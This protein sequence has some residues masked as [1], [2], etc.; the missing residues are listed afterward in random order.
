MTRPSPTPPF[1][2]LERRPSGA[3]GWLDARLLHDRWLEDLGADATAVLVLL[4]LAADRRGA[5]FYSRE[6]MARLLSLDLYRT[7]K[8]LD[9][10][11]EVKLVAHKPWR[12]GTRDGV[13]QLLPVPRLEIHRTGRMTSLADLID[14]AD[15]HD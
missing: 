2:S 6:R 14:G 15:P 5:S 10:L 7:D 11:I 1:P 3:F 4:A 8:A 12:E 9:R 13:W